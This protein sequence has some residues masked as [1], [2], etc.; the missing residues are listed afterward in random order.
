MKKDKCG[1]CEKNQS[2]ELHTCPYQI[3]INDNDKF[4]CDCCE[5]CTSDCALEV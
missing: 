1:R 3:E 5:D 4:E 2:R